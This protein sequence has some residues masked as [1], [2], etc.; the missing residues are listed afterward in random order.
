MKKLTK[1]AA[2]VAVLALGVGGLAACGGDGGDGG[3][4]GD[5]VTVKFM[6][7]NTV[8]ATQ[9]IDK[10]GKAVRPETD[11]T[12][13]G[14]DFIR[15]CATPTYSV[16]FNFDNEI[17]EDTTVFAGFR[18]QTADNH[19]WYMVG[20]SSLTD[21]FKEVGWKAVG[22]EA[23]EIA[24]S[25]IP[26]KVKFVKDAQVGNLFALTV[27]L[28]EGDMFKILNTEDGWDKDLHYGY[29]NPTQKSTA[30]TAG[31][32]SGGGLNANEANVKCQISGNYTIS[33]HVDADGKMTEF[34]Y[35]RNGDAP[36]LA[37]EF[38]YYIK[39]KYITAWQDM[40]VPFTQFKTEDNEVYNLTIGMKAS[41][42]FMFL[43][44]RRG[45]STG[46][47][48]S[49]NASGISLATD[50]DTAAAI[51]L[52]Q[53]S[54]NFKIKGGEGT[55]RFTITEDGES[56]TLSAEKTAQTLPEY[57][58]YVKGNIGGDTSW[59]ERHAMTKDGSL[60]KL[61]IDIAKDEE[62]T[63]SVAAHGD[64][65]KTELYG[66][67]TKYANTGLMSNQIDVDGWNFKAKAAD[68]FTIYVDPVTMLVYVEGINDIVTYDLGLWGA[69]TSSTWE[70]NAQKTTISTDAQALTGSIT[71]ELEAGKKF[72]FR[73]SRNGAQKGWANAS[74]TD[75]VTLCD[76]LTG[77]SDV[78]VE[79]AG[80]YKFDFT[81]DAS[82]NFTAI[83][84]TKQA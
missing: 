47:T 63:V 43:V 79:T 48:T 39:G 78:T 7:G 72:G 1:I 57:D 2:T 10:G 8:I 4:N 70:Y 77:T 49:L 83:V 21:L 17:E 6:D 61:E 24:E 65:D 81:I 46:A 19:S 82:G 51:E 60:Y 41:D 59:S 5:K 44:S 36:E 74:N 13:S 58:F 14:Y 45:D 33:L 25:D 29:M 84:A 18:S 27:D 23:G 32:I 52:P 73:S 22:T 16:V 34:D 67:N 76:G 12:K 30:E 62:F 38:D 80:T 54:A 71:V 26:E 64:A 66:L 35:V 69:W 20:E 53:G 37:A 9:T 3:G 50:A 15:W 42:D 28:Y 31:L 56:R 75:I 11:P 55:Y 68:T 40:V